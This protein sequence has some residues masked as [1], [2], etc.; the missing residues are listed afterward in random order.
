MSYPAVNP[1]P[2]FIVVIPARLASTRLP[3]KP[4][5]DIGG[6][7][8]IVRVAQQA[9]KSQASRVIVATDSGEVLDICE[10]YHIEALKT[11]ATHLTGTDRLSE[12][13]EILQL[14]DDEMLVNVQGDEPFVPPELI[15]LVAKA[16]HGSPSAAIATVGVALSHEADIQNPNI[17]KIVH[18]YLG[19][20][21]YFSRAPIPF[22]RDPKSAINPAQRLVPCLRHIGLYAYQSHFLRAFTSL[23]PAP[24]ELAES[25][26]QLRALWYGYKIQIMQSHEAPPAGVDTPEDLYRAQQKW[27]ELHPKSS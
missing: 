27:D 23:S 10:Q 13:V 14:P 11:R 22:L 6:A 25:L 26:E 3:R 16:L 15:N 9:Q 18:N 2:P 5:A 1:A 20:A 4:L 8:M 17:V 24:I 7:P 21:L 12:V 19:E